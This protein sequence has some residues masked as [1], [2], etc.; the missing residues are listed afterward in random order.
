[1]SRLKVKNSQRFGIVPDYI[2]ENKEISLE[3]RAV[4]AWLVGKPRAASR[5]VRSSAS[6]RFSCKQTTDV[7]EYSSSQ[8]FLTHSVHHPSGLTLP[9]TSLQVFD[10][11]MKFVQL[12]HFC[13]PFGLVWYWALACGTF[14]ADA[15]A[16]LAGDVVSFF[17]ASA[18][19]A[20]G[21]HRLQP[22]T[23]AARNTR[24]RL[25]ISSLMTLSFVMKRLNTLSPWGNE[26]L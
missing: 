16:G 2:L 3:A 23:R 8:A 21:I 20:S 9:S 19:S 6:C 4:A 11:A 15:A 10:S 17:V 24:L 18:A 13:S 14:L 12:L 26:V 5:S 1:M 25:G 22:V 7:Q